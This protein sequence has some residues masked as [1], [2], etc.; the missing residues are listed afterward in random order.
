MFHKAFT[1]SCEKIINFLKSILPAFKDG[2]GLTVDN[3]GNRVNF[4]LEEQDGCFGVLM[5][6][7]GYILFDVFCDLPNIKIFHAT[8]NSGEISLHP[9]V[10]YFLNKQADGRKH[11]VIDNVSAKP[12]QFNI[13]HGSNY[14]DLLKRIL[15]RNTLV[16]LQVLNLNLSDT[17]TEIKY[18]YSPKRIMDKLFINN[19]F[20]PLFDII[21]KNDDALKSFER[22]VNCA[23]NTDDFSKC[24]EWISDDHIKNVMREAAGKKFSKYE[25]YLLCNEKLVN[26]ESIADGEISVMNCGFTIQ[27]PICLNK[28][29]EEIGKLCEKLRAYYQTVQ[30]AHKMDYKDLVDRFIDMF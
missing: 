15:E 5:G 10:F 26:C 21:D 22:W 18:G 17:E 23:R 24:G 7:K 1:S 27:G 9:I 16:G 4:H 20:R 2:E 3:E 19:D 8:C 11:L 30:K 25:I 28:F 6:D 13:D 12:L 29:D 14:R